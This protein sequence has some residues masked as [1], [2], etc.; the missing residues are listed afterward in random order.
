MMRLRRNDAAPP[1]AWPP[2]MLEAG[3][4]AASASRWARLTL[5]ACLLAATAVA[6][7]E[8]RL[9]VL[10]PDTISVRMPAAEIA[11]AISHDDYPPAAFPAQ[12]PATTPEGGV[13]LLEVFS[14]AA[15]GWSLL[16]EIPDL[17]DA[18][19]RGVIRADQ[20]LYRVDGGLWSRGSPLPQV[21][22]SA[23]GPTGDWQ[24]LEID[25]R[26]E[27]VGTEPPGSFSVT[28]RVTALSDGEAP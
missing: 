16:L 26:L 3:Q 21:I 17:V 2:S 28:T 27:L 13:F 25:F 15:G 22:Y 7:S 12:Y 24:R 4:V 11:F 14:S 6:Q 1:A 23:V 19:G 8:W 10:I 5:A 9:D 18:A 20:V